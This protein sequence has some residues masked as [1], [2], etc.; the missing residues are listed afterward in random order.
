[1]TRG[2]FAGKVV[3]VTGGTRGLGR[4]VAGALIEHG[5]LVAVTGRQPDTL[6]RAC[7]DLAVN[8]SRCLPVAADV[9]DPVQVEAAVSSIV[10]QAGRLDAVV[11]AAGI[12]P[13]Y[14]RAEHLG[15]DD[16]RSIVDVNLSGTFF[17]LREAARPM[18]SSAGG[19]MV[20][21]SSLLGRVGAA[22][23]AAY[24]A[25]KGGVDQLVRALAIEWVDRGIRVNA[26]APGYV[27]TDMTAG[28]RRSPALVDRILEPTP[29]KR[30][31]RP[32]EIVGAVL[33]LISDA[34]SYVTG[35]SLPVDGGWSAG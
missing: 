17:T 18:L 4:A 21:V 14:V 32:E 31:A 23:L 35:V 25:S 2:E 9:S 6:E 30:F 10:E 24:C 34:A 33:Y 15:V 12:S 28:L 11:A 29:M 1:M 26:V 7:A 19:S 5:A 13:V 3:W 8:G 22:R 16:W 27:E 20:V